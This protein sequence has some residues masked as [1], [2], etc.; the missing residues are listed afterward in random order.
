MALLERFCSLRVDDSKPG[1]LTSIERLYILDRKNVADI[2]HM[3][4]K[5][6]NF[7]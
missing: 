1:H 5:E 4:L 2:N 6:F 3:S 7:K